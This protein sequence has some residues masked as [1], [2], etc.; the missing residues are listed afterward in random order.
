MK[1][2][3]LLLSLG[4]LASGCG[5]LT[6]CETPLNCVIACE[7]DNGGAGFGSGYRC[8]NGTCRDG[9]HG[10]RDCERICRN[11]VPAAG[12]DDDDSG[13]GDDDSGGAR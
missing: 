11:I 8:V 7:C 12:G 13:L 3:L 1:R 10:D 4:A 2:W 5:D 9:H 6:P